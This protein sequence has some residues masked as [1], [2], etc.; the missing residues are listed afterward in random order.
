MSRDGGL[1][2]GACLHVGVYVCAHMSQ[3]RGAEL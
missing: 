1:M 3:M 2:N